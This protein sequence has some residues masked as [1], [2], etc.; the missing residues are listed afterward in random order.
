VPGLA[1]LPAGGAGGGAGGGVPAQYLQHLVPPPP[2]SGFAP[3]INPVNM[4]LMLS[5]QGGAF[6]MLPM[7]LG[8]GMGG[9]MQQPQQPGVPPP[10]MLSPAEKKQREL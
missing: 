3:A 8:M 1:G 9:M 6:G 7:G 10:P 2:G 5:Q 4:A